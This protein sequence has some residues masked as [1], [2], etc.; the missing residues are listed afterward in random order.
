[1]V[2]VCLGCLFLPFDLVPGAFEEHIA[3]QTHHEQI[4]VSD[5]DPK[6]HTAGINR[7]AHKPVETQAGDVQDVLPLENNVLVMVA[8][9]FIGVGVVGVKQFSVLCAVNLHVLPEQRIQP[10]DAI[11]PVSHDLCVGVPPPGG[12][13]S[14]WPPERE[15]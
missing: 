4:E 7:E 9:D 14:S 13:G 5:A 11:L 8:G 2:H 10:Q 6:L 3:D 15:S 1:M 12:V